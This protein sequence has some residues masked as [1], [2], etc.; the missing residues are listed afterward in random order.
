MYTIEEIFKREEGI[1]TYSFK[2][3]NSNKQDHHFQIS[4][5]YHK[6][7]KIVTDIIELK[8]GDIYCIYP[9][10]KND[11]AAYLS[12]IDQKEEF[13]YEVL[14]SRY[15]D[16]AL[17]FSKK[18]EKKNIIID[19]KESCEKEY[20]D[21]AY[22]PENLD[23]KII[24][25]WNYHE[26]L[27]FTKTSQ[28]KIPLL[29]NDQYKNQY[30][31]L[32]DDCY[33]IINTDQKHEFDELFIVYL[34]SGK[35]KTWKLKQK[36]STD[37]YFLGT[38]NQV[39]YLFDRDNLVE[40]ALDFKKRKIEIVG[41]VKNN[42]KYYD[43]ISWQDKNIYDFKKQNLEFPTTLK[44]KQIEK[45]YTDAQ[46]YGGTRKYYFLYNHHLYIYYPVFDCY[47]LLIEN[48]ELKEVSVLNSSIYFIDQD[49]L[50]SYDQNKGL[51]KLVTSH[52]I[53]FNFYHAY[54]VSNS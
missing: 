44:N 12:C 50:Y 10:L 17:E 8:K 46:I 24:S 23:N 33:V 26:L 29:K 51:R 4:K 45:K 53:Q 52:E 41:N 54:T 9:K 34:K 43:G 25:L 14:K 32:V 21:V 13:S 16:V 31:I 20:Q 47:I 6:E 30:S 49:S 3:R 28:K 11:E 27:Y 5:N 37:C 2:I 36:I 19:Q 22:Y 7:K 1:H 18:L 39:I 38:V 40:Y 42:G 15:S 48:M 35:K